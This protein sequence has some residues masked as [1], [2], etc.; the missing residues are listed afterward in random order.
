MPE[1]VEYYININNI[2]G[3]EREREIES[4]FSLLKVV[5]EQKNGSS[6]SKCQNQ[7]SITFSLV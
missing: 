2:F 1:L 6:S 3:E 4:K 5:D 7:F